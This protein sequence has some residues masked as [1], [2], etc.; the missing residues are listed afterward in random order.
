[1]R[2]AADGGPAPWAGGT[3]APPAASLPEPATP[4]NAPEPAPSDPA[5]AEAERQI[6]ALEPPD[7]VKS[8][9][10]EGYKKALERYDR[11]LVAAALAQCQGRIGETCR[12]LGISRHQLRAKLER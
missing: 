9:A 3:A 6:L 5:P 1:M 2:V 12:L 11:Q 4:S 8:L 7:P 10:E